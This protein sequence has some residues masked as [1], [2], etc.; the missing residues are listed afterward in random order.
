[1]TQRGE[2]TR[3]EI[4]DRATALARLVGLRGVTIG[5]L[6]SDLSMSKSGLFA[7]FGSREALEIA[8]LDHAAEDFVSRVIRPTLSEPRGIP[9]LTSACER[10]LAWSQ[11]NGGCLFVAAV[12]ELDDCPGPVRD[13]L[14]EHERDWL[15]VLAQIVRS[16]VGDGWFRPEVDP[17]QIAFE[18][19]GVMLSTHHAFRLFGDDAAPQRAR[20][21][22]AALV[23]RI[24]A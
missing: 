2:T 4:L 8:I 14:V 12:T 19:H 3:T 23:D 15:D 5:Q 7:H 22:F 17:D 1:M 21:A 10:W 9:R 24:R 6:A 18:L 20:A 11:D 16:G 13:R